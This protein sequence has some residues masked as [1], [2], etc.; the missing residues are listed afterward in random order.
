VSAASGYRA[1]LREYIS[2]NANPPHKLGHQPRLYHLAAQIGEGLAYDDDVVYAATWL[3]DLGVFIGHRPEDPALLK[4]W[5]HVAYTTAVAPALLESWGFPPDKVPA[6]IEV[7]RTHQPHDEP[8]TVEAII[9]RDAD[10]LE[11][12]GAIGILR[13]ASKLGSDDRFVHFADAE[14][15]LSRALAELPAKIR[16]ETTRRLA[17]PRIETLRLFLAALQSEAMGELG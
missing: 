2:R 13:T 4:S 1:Q 6:A 17:A 11:Q 3:H 14:R 9:V 10:I 7:V 16:L 5:D 12:L 15:S 8:L